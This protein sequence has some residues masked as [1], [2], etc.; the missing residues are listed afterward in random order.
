MSLPVILLGTGGHARVLIDTLRLCSVEIIGA[1]NPVQ[2]LR[3]QEIFGIKVLGPDDEL[4]NYSAGKV[5]LVNAIGSVALPISRRQ[6]FAKWKNRGYVFADVIHPSAIIATESTIGE[7]AQVMAGVV[8]QPGVCLGDNVLINTKTSID[9]DSIIG[10]HSHLAPG[11]TVSGKVIMDEEVHV[12]AGATVIQCIQIGKGSLIGA[13]SLV[14]EN[15][16]AGVTA[17]GCPA[18]VRQQ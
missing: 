14:L 16:P 2:S 12:G 7:G 1:T 13:G 15:I 9:H 8:I 6:L 17:F 5:K 3:G 18:K 10:N 4:Y 11:V